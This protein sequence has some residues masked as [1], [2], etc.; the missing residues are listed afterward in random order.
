MPSYQI[1][2]L[3]EGGRIGL[4]ATF[5]CVDLEHALRLA[6]VIA[7]GVHQVDVWQGLEHVGRVEAAAA[8]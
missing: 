1:F 4:G 5:T 2:R 8:G 7:K 3:D 6:E